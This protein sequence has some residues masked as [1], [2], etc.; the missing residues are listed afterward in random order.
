MKET[1]QA[2]RRRQII[3]LVSL[4]MVLLVLSALS[5]FVLWPMVRNFRDPEYFRQQIEGKGFL[6]QLTMIGLVFMQVIIAFVP[7]EVF[8]VC[9]GYAFGGFEGSILCLVGTTS[10][11]TLIFL[12]V[13]RFG[14]HLVQLFF[15]R[16]RI[17]NWSFMKN[18]K[19][20]DLLTFILFLIPGTP[21]DLL[22][23]FIGLTPMKLPTFL[24]LS[25]LARLPSLLTSTVTG[26]MLGSEHYYLAVA[27][28][29]M[30]GIL[31]LVCIIWYRHEGNKQKK[32][33]RAQ[34]KANLPEDK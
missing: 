19:K 31:T 10:A 1:P 27:L 21:K 9:A 25:T 18:S 33:Q 6:G 30:T 24:L 2:L 5:Y 23:Y 8:E 3:T 32:M 26:G 16:E 34:D 28:Y 4:G 29:A 20:L 11:S 12:L 7:G 17:E 14:M 13:K 15:D 22:T